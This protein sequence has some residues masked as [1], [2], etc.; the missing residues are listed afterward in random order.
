MQ[1]GGEGSVVASVRGGRGRGR[2]GAGRGGG[3]GGSRGGR[4]SSTRPSSRTR[5]STPCTPL[6]NPPQPSFSSSFHARLLS[7]SAVLF[8]SLG[9]IMSNGSD[10]IVS[11]RVKIL[12]CIGENP[13]HRQIDSGKILSVVA[14]RTQTNL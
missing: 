2:R 10:C 6:P 11:N 14:T 3:R 1:S 9:N 13:K 7:N 12:G 4:G 5:A 8:S